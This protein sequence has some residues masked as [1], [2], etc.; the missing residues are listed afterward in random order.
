MGGTKTGPRALETDVAARS[1]PGDP[2]DSGEKPVALVQVVRLPPPIRRSMQQPNRR[3]ILR[4]SP[5]RVRFLAE[6]RRRGEVP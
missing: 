4:I 3:Y 5:N 2:R 1:R 6:H